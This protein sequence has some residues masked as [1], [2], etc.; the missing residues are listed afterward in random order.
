VRAVIAD[1][2]ER[3]HRSNLVGMGVLPLQFR[4]GQSREALGL[5]G[6]ETYAISGLVG[7][8][9]REVTVSAVPRAGAPIRFTAGVRVDTPREW[10]Y[11]RHGGILPYALGKLLA[12]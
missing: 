5:T 8:A 9:P 7:E 6:R 2:Y 10:D 3:I 12:G 4:D 1:S 11:L